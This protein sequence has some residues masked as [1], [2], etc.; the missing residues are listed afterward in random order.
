[1]GGGGRTLA[2][3]GLGFSPTADIPCCQ[4]IFKKMAASTSKPPERMSIESGP[5]TFHY[6]IDGGEVRMRGG[7]CSMCPACTAEQ[8]LCN[9]KS[10]LSCAKSLGAAA[11]WGQP[12]PLLLAPRA[13]RCAAPRPAGLLPDADR[14]GLPQEAGLPVPGGAAE[15]VQPAVWRADRQRHAAIRLYQVW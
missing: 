11:K 9:A 6:L 3:A 1:M 7:T 2:V 10:V 5:F 12:V 14:E 13:A 8:L 15:R 4:G